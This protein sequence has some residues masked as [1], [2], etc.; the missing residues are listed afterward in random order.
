[1]AVLLQ[2]GKQLAE[3]LVQAVQMPR[4]LAARQGTQHRI[5]VLYHVYSFR[6]Y[7]QVRLRGPDG[8]SS[9]DAGQHACAVV[10]VSAIPTG[11]LVKAGGVPLV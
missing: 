8:S 1:M 9:K 7:R 4:S 3:M 10:W 2:L 11:M 6:S 5:P